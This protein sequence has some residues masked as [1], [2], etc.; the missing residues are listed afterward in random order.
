M[1][2]SVSDGL[3]SI[4]TDVPNHALRA[5]VFSERGGKEMAIDVRGEFSVNLSCIR[6]WVMQASSKTVSSNDASKF[7][8]TDALAE[9]TNEQRR[10]S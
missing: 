6:I 9:D 2:V 3:F 1:V 4:T 8:S 10:F 7:V 5:I